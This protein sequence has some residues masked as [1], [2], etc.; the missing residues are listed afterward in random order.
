MDMLSIFDLCPAFKDKEIRKS[1]TYGLIRGVYRGMPEQKKADCEVLYI[2]LASELDPDCSEI[3]NLILIDDRAVT[4]AERDMNI[5]LLDKN[6]DADELFDFLQS[7]FA[8]TE[9]V[10]HNINKMLWH[11]GLSPDYD[12]LLDYASDIAGNPI[13]MADTNYRVLSAGKSFQK[14]SEIKD[15]QTEYLSNSLISLFEEKEIQK[16]LVSMQMPLKIKYGS[17]K[18]IVI[19]TVAVNNIVVAFVILIEQSKMPAPHDNVLLRNLSNLVSI[20]L[21]MQNART[22][23]NRS[24][25]NQLMEDLLS[26]RIRGERRIIKSIS[27]LGVKLYKHFYLMVLQSSS[28]LW[29]PLEQL[30][31]GALPLNFI[32][33]NRM[34]SERCSLMYQELTD[35]LVILI[36]TDLPE[37]SDDI[38]LRLESFC[39]KNGFRATLSLRYDSI[40][41]TSFHYEALGKMLKLGVNK[42]GAHKLN[43]CTD[44]IFCYLADACGS[45][46]Y[47]RQI[48]HPAVIQMLEHDRTHNSALLPTLQ[49]YLVWP[50]EPQKAADSLH[51]HRNTLFSRITKIREVFGIDLSD[52]MERMR[53]LLSITLLNIDSIIQ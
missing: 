4:I 37:F 22:D 48:C 53:L 52:G 32:D 38:I 14:N 6:A 12:Y 15:E 29:E 18:E 47:L 17:E 3:R 13:I 39:E 33:F 40:Q 5:I 51:I 21:Q 25:Y 50:S 2:C 31:V 19:F 45:S 44:Y 7:E 36:S 49:A 26:G 28:D 24:L 34:I 10:M 46:E 27:G 9:R 23:T 41:N 42:E 30:P 20:S 43:I 11:M 35:R 8:E 16:R 1:R